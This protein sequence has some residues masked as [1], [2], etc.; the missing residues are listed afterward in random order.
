MITTKVIK[1]GKIA[2]ELFLLVLPSFIYVVV[3]TI[4][5][6]YIKCRNKMYI[7]IIE[8]LL[9]VFPIILKITVLSNFGVNISYA[10]CISLFEIIILIIIKISLPE[11]KTTLTKLSNNHFITNILRYSL[12]DF[13]KPQKQALV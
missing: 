8:Y 4:V 2:V 10:V 6:S 13:L 3:S 11:T 9:L 5:P 12:Q 7:Y 1:D